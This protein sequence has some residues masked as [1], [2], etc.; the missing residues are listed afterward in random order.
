[1]EKAFQPGYDPALEIASHAKSASAHL[2]IYDEDGTEHLR[3]REQELVD[4]IIS[5]Q[6]KG[7]YYMLIGPKV[8]L[9][10]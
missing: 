7:H 1:M 9:D 3:R 6:E 8:C 4:R 2:S 5:G 10:P